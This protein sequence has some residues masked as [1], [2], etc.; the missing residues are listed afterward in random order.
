MQDQGQSV[1]GRMAAAI[2]PIVPTPVLILPY[3]LCWPWIQTMVT[4]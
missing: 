4:D 1:P 3:P 2:V